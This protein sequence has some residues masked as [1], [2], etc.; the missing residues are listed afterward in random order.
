M[1][2]EMAR[3][4]ETLKATIVYVTHDQA[5]AMTLADRIVVLNAGRIEQVGAPLA[6][7][8]RPANLFVATFLGSP[9]INLLPATV[10]ACAPGRL[11]VRVREHV[12]VSVTGLD[13]VS[14]LRAGDRVTLGIRPEHFEVTDAPAAGQPVLAG[15]VQLVEHFGDVAY[16]HA[17]HDGGDMLTARVPYDSPRRA[18]DEVRFT[19]PPDEALVFDADGRALRQETS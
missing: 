8:R 18:G 11:D 4:H 1:R 10:Q 17:L 7:Y 6:L 3:L 16:L 15:A 2:V 19:F 12:A 13:G 9:R 14:S 5:E